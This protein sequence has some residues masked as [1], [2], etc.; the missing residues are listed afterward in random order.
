MG[1]RP[2]LDKSDSLQTREAEVIDVALSRAA[3][4]GGAAIV[5]R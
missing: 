1:R 3:V 5:I 4:S 2:D